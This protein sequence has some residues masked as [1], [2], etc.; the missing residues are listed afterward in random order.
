MKRGKKINITPLS[1]YLRENKLGM[2]DYKNLVIGIRNGMNT[3]KTI[4]FDNVYYDG[5]DIGLTPLNKEQD[6]Y[7]DLSRFFV[8]MLRFCEIDN[9]ETL[10]LAYSL[11]VTS[12]R[13]DYKIE[14]LVR[15]V[16]EVKA[17]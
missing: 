5:K 12:S 15:V 8:R 1:D 17:A 4:D 6:F 2:K 14:D 16:E 7:Y 3:L 9:R 13:T 10:N 11:F